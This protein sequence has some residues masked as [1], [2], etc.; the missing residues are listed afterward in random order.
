M[1]RM[2]YLTPK[3]VILRLENCVE[4][5]SGSNIKGDFKD[6]DVVEEKTDTDDDG[7]YIPE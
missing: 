5:L 7:W 1:K 6:I 3:I 4:I 2:V